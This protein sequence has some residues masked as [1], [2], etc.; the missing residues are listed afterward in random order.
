MIFGN[1]ILRLSRAKKVLLR[2]NVYNTYDSPSLNIHINTTYMRYKII[3]SK[4]NEFLFEEQ[5]F[6]NI[7]TRLA[8]NFT[9]ASAEIRELKSKSTRLFWPVKNLLPLVSFQ[10]ILNKNAHVQVKFSKKNI[11]I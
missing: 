2:K 9:S 6:K 7:I 11:L 5:R 4:N 8:R 1:L 3:F 10:Q